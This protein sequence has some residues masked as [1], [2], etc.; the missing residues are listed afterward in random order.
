MAERITWVSRTRSMHDGPE[1]AC[2]ASMMIHESIR[3]HVY[4]SIHVCLTSFATL[5]LLFKRGLFSNIAKNTFLHLPRGVTEPRGDFGFYF[6]IQTFS[7]MFASEVAVSALF[8]GLHNIT[9]RGFKCKM[10]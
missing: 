8:Y 6:D 9:N 1:P 10:H 7:E 4:S 5:R 3:P 2:R